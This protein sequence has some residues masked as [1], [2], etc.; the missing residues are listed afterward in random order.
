M[1]EYKKLNIV[2]KLIY[3]NVAVYI[4]TQLYRLFLTLF[5]VS[6][7]QWQ[8]YLALHSNINYFLLTPWTVFT[9]FFTH[10]D[11]GIDL[12]HIVFN[13]LWLWWFGNYFRYRVNRQFLSV[14]LLGGIFRACSSFSYIIS[15]HIFCLKETL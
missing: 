12:F 4:V 9:Y 13:M 5:C 8:D 11:L 15:S 2:G 10:A 3:I 1:I 7:F 6:G 14:Y